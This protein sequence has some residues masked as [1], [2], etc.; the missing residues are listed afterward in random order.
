MF[1]F[2]ADND[3]VKRGA[4][5][6]KRSFKELTHGMTVSEKVDYL[7]EYYKWVLL[8]AVFIVIVASMVITGIVNTSKQVLYSGAAVNVQMSEEGSGYL[9][10]QLEEHL[11]AT[12][13][14][15]VELFSTA[16]EDLQTTSDVEYNAMSAMQLALMIAA[17]DYDYVIMDQLALDFYR[18]HPV[19]TALDEMFSEELLSQWENQIVNHEGMPIAIDITDTAFVRG[20]VLEGERVYIAFPGNTG[21]TEFNDDFLKYLMAWK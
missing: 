15:S 14:Q 12:K 17:E 9:T 2:F 1:G 7:W 8:V 18:N 13:R 20:C 19:F 10:E 4:A 3:K 21:R 6:A 11:G 16:F 5:M